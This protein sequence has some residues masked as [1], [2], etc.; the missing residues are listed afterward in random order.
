VREK[1]AMTTKSIIAAENGL[2]DRIMVPAEAIGLE[3][4]I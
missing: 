3:K 2:K 4:V 1:T